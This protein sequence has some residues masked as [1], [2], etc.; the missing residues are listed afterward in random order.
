MNSITDEIKKELEEK[1]NTRYP[2]IVELKKNETIYQTISY[3]F[4]KNSLCWEATVLF[5]SEANTVRAYFE[6]QNSNNI[7]KK[8]DILFI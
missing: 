6:Y 5:N 4:N 3:N 7:F 2:E 8:F 1:L